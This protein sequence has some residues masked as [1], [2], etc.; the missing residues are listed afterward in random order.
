M[1]F[2]VYTSK[3]QENIDLL[4]NPT[5]FRNKYL[6]KID[7]N[8]DIINK[9]LYDDNKNI[10]FVAKWMRIHSKIFIKSMNSY[11]N[12]VIHKSVQLKIK[13]DN[14]VKRL[15]NIKGLIQ[16]YLGLNKGKCVNARD[17]L[18]FIQS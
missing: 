15:L 13:K 16:I 4:Y 14:R 7:K 9:M 10:Q 3:I 2:D 12:W 18:N 6:V 1:P 5:V 11:R 17:I 8:I